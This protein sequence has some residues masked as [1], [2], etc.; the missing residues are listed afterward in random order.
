MN[1]L[2]RASNSTRERTIVIGHEREARLPPR[3]A[4]CAAA[5][6]HLHFI[7]VPISFNRLPLN[8]YCVI[9]DFVANWV[10]QDNIPVI[11]FSFFFFSKR[12]T[13]HRSLILLIFLSIFN[14][15]DWVS[16]VLRIERHLFLN[17]IITDATIITNGFFVSNFQ[18]KR[19]YGEIF[20]PL[21]IT[22][23]RRHREIIIDRNAS[24]SRSSVKLR[25]ARFSQLS[26]RY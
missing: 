9:F 7:L 13:N 8:F 6:A 4:I 19:K 18:I 16:F 24:F 12:I 25:R 23:L 14:S 15:R 11:F 21:R 20:R 1:S 22:C 17:A 26:S 2:G 10:D 5:S 3:F